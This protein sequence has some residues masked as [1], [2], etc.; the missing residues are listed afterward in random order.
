MAVYDFLWGPDDTECRQNDHFW[1]E[2]A[3]LTKAHSFSQ[4]TVLMGFCQNMQNRPK[5][6]KWR[7]SAEMTTFD[8]P[9]V[10]PTARHETAYFLDE[11][12]QKLAIMSPE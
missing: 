10:H 2:I 9:N 4:L 7:Y 12:V 8:A 6:A 3:L 5:R 11:T 1:T